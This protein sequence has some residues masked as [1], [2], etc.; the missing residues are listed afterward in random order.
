VPYISGFGGANADF[1][2]RANSDIVLCDSNP[3]SFSSSPGGVMRNILDNL[4]RLGIETALI[5]A[6]GND[7]AG[8]MLLSSCEECGIDTKAIYI[9][10]SYPSC[11]YVDFLKPNGDMFVAANDMKLIENFPL[12]F[13]EN[14]KELIQKSKLLLLDTN[15]SQEAIIEFA[16]L[17]DGIPIFADPVSTAKAKRLLPVLDKLTL[18]KP[19]IYELSTLTGLS[20]NS[21][22]EIEKAAKALLEKGVYSV[23]VSMGEHGVYYT[24]QQDNNFYEKLEKAN[25]KNATGAGDAFL[26]GVAYAFL[27]GKNAKDMVRFGL[28]MGKL[29]VCSDATI[30]ND[31]NEQIVLK[32][33]EE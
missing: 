15:P 17:G 14:C 9:S 32:M 13:L 22:D 19:N 18:I 33:I 24:D 5:S 12:S 27:K 7:S 4:S 11:S 20:C 1:H 8:K 31:L 10:S 25:M 30:N 16:K 3:S 6:V 26:A 23:I 21:H 2:I 28:G 29:A